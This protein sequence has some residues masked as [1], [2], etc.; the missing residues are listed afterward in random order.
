M[1]TCYIQN[2]VCITCTC[3]CV[4]VCGAAG[5]LVLT[6]CGDVNGSLCTDSAA[7]CCVCVRTERHRDR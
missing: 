2:I 7:I 4:N 5:N 6:E 1:C 3:N